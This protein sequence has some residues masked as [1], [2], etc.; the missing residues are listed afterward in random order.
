MN[1]PQITATM[2]PTITTTIGAMMNGRILPIMLGFGALHGERFGLFGER[3]NRLQFAELAS[4][5]GSAIRR[6]TM[7]SGSSTRR[8]QVD[9]VG[10]DVGVGLQGVAV[11]QQLDPLVLPALMQRARVGVVV[12]GRRE[13]VSPEQPDQQ[14]ADQDRQRL[15]GGHV[16]L[17]QND[18]DPVVSIFENFIPLQ[19]FVRRRHLSIVT[20]I[21]SG[22]Q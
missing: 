9:D 10:A 2:L 7:P 15:D 12:D 6:S 8:E 5:P 17:E 20:E 21:A 3:T 1:M 11:G 14:T 22:R 16:G 18:E 19:P 4:S 13:D